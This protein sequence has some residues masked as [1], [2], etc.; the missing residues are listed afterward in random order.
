M[1]ECSDKFRLYKIDIIVR[2]I[3][4]TT[5]STILQQNTNLHSINPVQFTI[6]HISTH[7]KKTK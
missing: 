5:K 1:K 3:R 6:L 4:I 2:Y 7:K